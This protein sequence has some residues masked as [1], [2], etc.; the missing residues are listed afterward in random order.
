MTGFSDPFKNR[1]RNET[2]KS[3]NVS[4]RDMIEQRVH[5]CPEGIFVKSDGIE[6]TWRD[7]DRGSSVIAGELYALGAGA[8]SH[9][10]L[11][12]ANSVNWILTFFAIQKIGAVAVLLNSQLTS[13]EITVFSKRGDITH[14]CL[15]NTPI[16]NRKQ[17]SK[18]ILDPERS[19]I[20]AVLDVGDEI[21]FLKKPVTEFPDVVPMSDDICVII[22]TSG[23]TATPKGVQLSAFCLLNSSDFCVKNLKMTVDDRVCA[24]LPFFHIFGLTAVLLS[25]VI[26][27]SLI[28]LPRSVKPDDLMRVLKHEKCTILHTVPT[29]FIRLVNAPGF[30][31]R[32]VSGIRASYMSGAPMSEAQLKM[33]MDKFPNNHFM[34]RYGLTEMT[35][36]TSTDLEDDINHILYTVGKPTDGTDMRIK[37]ME[38][39]RFCPAGIQGEIVVKGAFL[40]SG[41][42]KQ[43]ADKQPFDEDG[44]LHTGDLGF[45]DEE[46]YLHFTGRAKDIIIRGGENIM[47]NEVASAIS[48]HENVVDVKVIG[49]PDEIYGEIVTAAVVLKDGVIFD[50]KEMRDFLMTKLAKYKIPTYFFI[51]EKLPSLANGKIDAVSLKKEIISRLGNIG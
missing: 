11:C 20:K 43:P 24:I 21:D 26:S 32:L 1:V 27:G 10:A 19:Q 42:Y 14:F 9:V 4:I 51:Y 28:I 23:S 5:E 34:K 44:F 36:V 38:T 30:T 46:G 15:G 25:C 41:Y 35:P 7:I 13:E 49:V 16:R 29:V 39:G 2:D 48:M 31:I 22:F 12:G 17:F 45:L 3:R 6:Y 8:G 47:P 33:L 18:E 37:D 40:M 50:G